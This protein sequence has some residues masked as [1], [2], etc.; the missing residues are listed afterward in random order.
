MNTLEDTL[1]AALIDTAAEIS[2]DHLPPL[3]LPAR[4]AR[5]PRTT[6][7]KAMT[8]SYWARA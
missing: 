3:R 4:P 6:S 5:R 2:P 7:P 8:A 1:V